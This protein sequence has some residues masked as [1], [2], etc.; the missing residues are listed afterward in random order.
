M[1]AVRRD[2]HEPV[3]LLRLAAVPPELTD[4]GEVHRLAIF[5]VDVIGLLL[6]Q[7]CRVLHPLVPA[8]RGDHAASVLPDGFE[9]L[10]G[11]RRLAPGID[12][13]RALTL[14]PERRPTPG[15]QIPAQAVLIPVQYPHSRP[16]RHVVPTDRLG[17]YT[18]QQRQLQADRFQILPRNSVL[19]EPPAHPHLLSAPD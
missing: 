19:S 12:R 16:W 9:E 15:H 7:V 1:V 4:S 13:W 17:I 8:V 14:R 10:A 18:T 5:S 3:S 6:L 2:D 11:G